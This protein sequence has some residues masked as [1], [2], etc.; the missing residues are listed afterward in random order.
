VIRWLLVIATLLAFPGCDVK[1]PRRKSPAARCKTP[2]A[3]VCNGT[4]CEIPVP[5]GK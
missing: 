3:P 2:A 4:E 1:R 5:E